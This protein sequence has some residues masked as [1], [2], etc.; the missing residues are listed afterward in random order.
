MTKLL[1]EDKGAYVSRSLLES[2]LAKWFRSY[3]SGYTSSGTLKIKTL[4]TG[5]RRIIVN[6]NG[7]KSS[8]ASLT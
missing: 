6:T 3:E 5:I 4:Y 7:L 1:S 8:T 2:I